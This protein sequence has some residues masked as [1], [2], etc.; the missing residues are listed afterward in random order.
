MSDNTEARDARE[1]LIQARA[2]LMREERER[3]ERER[4]RQDERDRQRHRQEDHEESLR[5]ARELAEREGRT[6]RWDE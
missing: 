2:Q 4:Q 1:S 6:L 3:Q 5:A